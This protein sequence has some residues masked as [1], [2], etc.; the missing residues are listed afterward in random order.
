MSPRD[1][2]AL[3]AILMVGV[4]ASILFW[5]AAKRFDPTLPLV[6]RGVTALEALAAKGDQTD[7]ILLVLQQMQK[8]WKDYQESTDRLFRIIVRRI[9]A[10]DPALSDPGAPG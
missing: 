1:V 4:S 7:K 10:I 9:N 2:V 5:K 8:D 3:I 6:Q